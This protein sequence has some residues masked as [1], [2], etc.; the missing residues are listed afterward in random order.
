MPQD[1]FELRRSREVEQQ[2]LAK[3][4]GVHK[5]TLSQ[6][7]RGRTELSLAR[8]KKIAEFL[9]VSL[10]VVYSA[11]EETRRRWNARQQAPDPPNLD[12][13]A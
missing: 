1:L 11:A 5:A 13:A 3:Y 9:K 2:A 12:E 6:I 4:M 10:D 8:A 7:E